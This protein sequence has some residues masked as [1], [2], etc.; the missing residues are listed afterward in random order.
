MT[1]PVATSTGA[2]APRLR[3]DDAQARLPGTTRTA[4][5]EWAV[6]CEALGR[7]QQILLIR[8][9]GISEEHREFRVEHPEFS[10]DLTARIIRRRYGFFGFDE[11]PIGFNPERLF[12]L[13]TN[14]KSPARCDKLPSTAGLLID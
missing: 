4:L 12:N 7:G 10:F 9:G 6:A 1:T 3:P 14:D 13:V 5:K 11:S 8:K 2:A